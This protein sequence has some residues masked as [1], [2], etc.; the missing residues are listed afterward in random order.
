MISVT[1]NTVGAYV[2]RRCFR[3]VSMTQL[4]NG[5]RWQQDVRRFAALLGLV[6]FRAVD[7]AMA[8]VVEH[9]LAQPTRRDHFRYVLLRWRRL[10]GCQRWIGHVHM[11]LTF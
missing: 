11:P 6:A 8:L 5:N 1:Q 7:R 9:R 2:R 4:A 3:I 10:I